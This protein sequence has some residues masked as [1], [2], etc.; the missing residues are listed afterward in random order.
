MKTLFTTILF[1]FSC[2]TFFA[3][4]MEWH[5]KL[6]LPK[7]GGNIVA[8][9]KSG[10]EMT[11][12]VANDGI[13]VFSSFNDGRT[14]RL[15]YSNE[16]NFSLFGTPQVHNGVIYY[17]LSFTTNI[18]SPSHTR[19]IK[20]KNSLSSGAKIDDEFLNSQSNSNS[21]SGLKKINNED[22]YFQKSFVARAPKTTVL[23]GFAN[24]SWNQNTSGEILD[25]D[26]I[27]H[28]DGKFLFEKGIDSLKFY[29]DWWQNS[30][31]T[32]ITL[33]FPR[34]S[35]NANGT[36]INN[37]KIFR[38]GKFGNFFISD[39]KGKEIISNQIPISNY[40]VELHRGRFFFSNSQGLFIDKDEE[41]SGV[42]TVFLNDN[43]PYDIQGFY[44]HGNGDVYGLFDC[45]KIGKT[46]DLGKT[47]NFWSPIGIAADPVDLEV[48]FLDSIFIKSECSGSFYLDCDNDFYET[49]ELVGTTIYQTVDT[50]LMVKGKKLLFS[51]DDGASWRVLFQNNNDLEG[52]AYINQSIVVHD[53]QMYHSQDFG[54]SWD[55]L[56]FK[57]VK[58][59][60]SFRDYLI[61][62]KNDSLYQSFDFETFE[63]ISNSLLDNAWGTN[64]KT[65]WRI[66]GSFLYYKS[67]IDSIWGRSSHSLSSGR[68]IVSMSVTNLDTIMVVGVNTL[69]PNN[70]L[71]P[72][73]I[74]ILSISTDGGESWSW[75]YNRPRVETYFSYQ[76]T[77]DFVYAYS[78]DKLYQS[79]LSY[80]LSSTRPVVEDTIYYCESTFVKIG[81]RIFSEPQITMISYPGA[82]T[83]DS[84]VLT[85]IVEAP[86]HTSAVDTTVNVGELVS[87]YPML[88]DTIFWFK[89]ETIRGC[90]SLI[91]YRVTV[92]Q[93]NSIDQLIFENN[94]QIYPNPYN[95]QSELNILFN[96]GIKKENIEIKI[97]NSLGKEVVFKELMF[98][99]SQIK[100]NLPPIQSGVYFVQISKIGY[101]PVLK[102]LMILNY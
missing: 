92:D 52:G 79:K 4:Y 102:K 25:G 67:D 32:A 39:F 16:D 80:L 11:A 44:F 76:L 18:G 33:S 8:I 87:S 74:N 22:L 97:F 29:H 73:K 26:L 5:E 58:Q 24:S 95:N 1:V 77:K 36:F 88:N 96:K 62:E 53:S 54:N 57:D 30:L 20:L 71:P 61:V 51:E 2:S 84:L 94:I 21:Y 100:L 63:K 40:D 66:N 28:I 15:K 47:W 46:T 50:V 82:N 6:E 75:V 70:P 37:G 31:D 85:E 10:N 98:D 78:G 9:G 41:V 91:F 83:C 3:Q 89:G 68:G 7:L 49:N 45:G 59:V 86:R 69:F 27:G 99:R 48:G 60:A 81:D 38:F 14:W 72:K 65:L 56:N 35:Y 23:Q 17:F 101:Q 55:T 19:Y 12:L 34:H 43:Y 93:T 90:D 42:D 13:K 64:S